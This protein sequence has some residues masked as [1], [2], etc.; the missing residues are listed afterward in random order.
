MRGGRWCFEGS[1]RRGFGGRNW[2]RSRSE[3]LY[4]TLS[5]SILVQASGWNEFKIHSRISI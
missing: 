5:I 1:E 3:K 2:G 4:F